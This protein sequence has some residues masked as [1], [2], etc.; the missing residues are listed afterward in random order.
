MLNLTSVFY[1]L[2][3]DGFIYETNE[4][5]TGMS[6]GELAEISNYFWELVEAE[7]LGLDIIDKIETYI[8]I[9]K[10]AD[11][12][13]AGF[14]GLDDEL[15]GAYFYYDEDERTIDYYGL[16]DFLESELKEYIIEYELEAA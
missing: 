10:T 16:P 4:N 1:E 11:D 15:L 8:S 13:T 6:Y 3:E 7:L 12:D 14:M 5:G 2:I 9:L